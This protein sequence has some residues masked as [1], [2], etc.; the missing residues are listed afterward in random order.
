MSDSVEQIALRLTRLGFSQYEARTY[1]GLLVAQGT[2]GYAISN[3]T[4]VPQPKV[5]ETLRRLVERGAVIQTGQRPAR[6]AA[7]PPDQ[8]LAT[9]EA[10]F[11][12][13]LDAARVGLESLPR[14]DH[15]QPPMAVSRLDSFEGVVEQAREGIAR[16]QSRV[17]LHGRAGELHPLGEVVGA[18]VERGVRF[19]IV[20][21]GPLPFPRPRGQVV[22]HASTEGT[23]YASR[24][25]RHLAAVVD[26]RW[27]LWAL[28][29]DGEHWEGLHSDAPLLA[30]LVKTYIRH[31]LFVQRIY[32][33][34]PDVLEARYGPG[35]LKLADL[36]AD[37]EEADD[38]VEGAG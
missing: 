17:Y 35:L 5:Y 6:Y 38:L 11:R 7:V 18:A 27:S 8:L 13:R 28:A 21:F 20:H 24:Q 9:L 3:Q 2:T 31:D 15:Q 30:S 37:A 26:S 36:S 19:V 16:A 23:L 32:A 22:R 1:V 10:D 34:S 14:K 12:S 33:D 25:V 29:R 4:G